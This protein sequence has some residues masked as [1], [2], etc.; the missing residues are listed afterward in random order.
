M[1]L[2]QKPSDERVCKFIE[3]QSRL[4]FTYPSVGT[5][6]NGDHPSG[7]TVDHNRIHLGEGKATFDAAK[8]ALHEWQ[9]YR[10][11]WIELH[12]PDVNPEPDQTVGVLAHAL[13]LWVLNACRIVY[14][15]E[16]KYPVYRFAFAYGTLP[17]HAESGEERFQVEWHQ[18]D[19]SVWY[20]ILSFSRPNQLISRLA[21]PYVRQ[22]QK[23][24]VKDSMLTMKAAVT[25][26]L[27]T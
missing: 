23:L 19:D 27:L 12:R 13:G 18:K 20:D 16:E 4:D 24:F 25:H 6:R 5:T 26:I 11:N 9:H 1:Y 8:Q 3:S 14:V 7:Y 2:I 22:K 21:Y 15:V 17:E 10:F